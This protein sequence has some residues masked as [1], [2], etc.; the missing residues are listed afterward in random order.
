MWPFRRNP[1]PE[2]E[3]ERLEFYAAQGHAASQYQLG[4]KYIDTNAIGK[5]DA[6]GIALLQ[7]AAE[8]GAAFAS[9]TLSMIYMGRGD[10]MTGIKWLQR[11]AE[12]GLA[13]AQAQL[14]LFYS[15]D[16]IIPQDDV[17]AGAWM[18]VAVANDC[19]GGDESLQKV[20]SRLN[21]SQK[22]DVQKLAAE[23]I[24]R[25]PR[26]PFSDHAERVGLM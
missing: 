11:A 21:A 17:K 1:P 16:K 25:L 12:Q 22:A 9:N 4:M 3:L 6:K 7:K 20:L 2:T 23:L 13:N 14:G 24:A 10:F 26:I 18:T 5:D 19:P 15:M 8:Q